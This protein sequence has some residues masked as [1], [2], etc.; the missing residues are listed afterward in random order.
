MFYL[1]QP[2]ALKQKNA[3]TI[4]EYLKQYHLISYLV[5]NKRKLRHIPLFKDQSKFFYFDTGSIEK[6]IEMILQK[7][8][9]EKQ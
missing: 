1:D 4:N 9:M 8:E 7:L 3:D 2:Y 6:I 5:P